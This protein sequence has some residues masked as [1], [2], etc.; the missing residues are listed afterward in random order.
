[1]PGF[2]HPMDVVTHM[3]SA[4]GYRIVRG[5]LMVQCVD[6]DTAK[7]RA[8]LGG[9]WPPKALP[10]SSGRPDKA[11]LIAQQDMEGRLA[12]RKKRLQDEDAQKNLEARE[13]RKR[14]ATARAAWR[15]EE[16]QEYREYVRQQEAAEEKAEADGRPY[17]E[18]NQYRKRS[19]PA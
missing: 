5:F 15:E 8:P 12:L 16:D 18:S 11:P 10:L 6:G 17:G 4:A 2:Q 9:F 1:M 3:N 7:R 13:E 19:H 14:K